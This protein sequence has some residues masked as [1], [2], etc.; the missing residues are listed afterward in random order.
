MGRRSHYRHSPCPWRTGWS[1][2]NTLGSCTED[3][4]LVPLAALLEKGS[5]IKVMGKQEW[6]GRYAQQGVPSMFR[7]PIL[8]WCGKCCKQFLWKK[9]ALQLAE[10]R[11]SPR[12]QDMPPLSNTTRGCYRA[13]TASHLSCYKP[14]KNWVK[15]RDIKWKVSQELEKPA[16]S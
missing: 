4:W 16:A 14:H 13:T 10:L 15:H 1:S 2:I 7:L 8:G 9:T 5:S 3:S 12:H 11:K 6:A